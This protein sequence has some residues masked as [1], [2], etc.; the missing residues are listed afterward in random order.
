[1][2]LMR[3]IG[4]P[5]GRPICGPSRSHS[6]AN[7]FRRASGCVTV[8]LPMSYCLVNSCCAREWA[9]HT[10][11][12]G[13]R[14]VFGLRTAK[15]IIFNHVQQSARGWGLR[16][17]KVGSKETAGIRVCVGKGTVVKQQHLHVVSRKEILIMGIAA[18]VGILP[19]GMVKQQTKAI[20]LLCLLL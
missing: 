12:A 9:G 8:S 15:A 7:L 16:C 6:R 5:L 4:L 2:R 1:M 10:R 17:N 20:C 18:G 3:T 19:A 11:T 14:W 13:C